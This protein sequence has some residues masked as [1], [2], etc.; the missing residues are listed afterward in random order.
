MN[1]IETKGVEF[2]TNFRPNTK[3]EIKGGYQLLY[4]NDIDVKNRFKKGDVYAKDD[5]TL[6]SFKLGKDDYFGLFNRSRHMG[7]FKLYYDLNEKVKIN[8]II[9]YRSKYA[10]ND[11]NANGF[12]DTYDEFIEGYAL[13]D[14]GVTHHTTSL[15]SIQLGIKNIFNFT[16]PEYI[17]NISGRLYY[18]NLKITLNK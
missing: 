8:T 12:L 2:N 15:R 7:N 16:N 5:E 4:A 10:L 17:S 1:Q 14:V 11:S 13:C 18:M 3:L 6:V 9:T